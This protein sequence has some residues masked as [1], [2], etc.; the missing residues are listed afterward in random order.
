[1]TRQLTDSELWDEARRMATE[2][3]DKVAA[4]RKIR[5]MGGRDLVPSEDRF[6]DC[7]TRMATQPLFAR[8][9]VR[10]VARAE[11]QADVLAALWALTPASD[12]HADELVELAR[13]FEKGS[14]EALLKALEFIGSSALEERARNLW[15]RLYAKLEGTNAR[16]VASAPAQLELPLDGLGEQPADVS[17]V[18]A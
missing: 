18:P 11:F 7:Y 12:D 13:D 10:T 6:F 3:L 1:M 2:G 14:F 8:H 16:P 15:S 9:W 17:G 5:T 4:F